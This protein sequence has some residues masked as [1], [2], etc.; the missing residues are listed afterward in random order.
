MATDENWVTSHV[1]NE[2]SHESET[3]AAYLQQEC[4]AAVCS[5]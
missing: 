2:A 3:A 4:G 5:A 1:G